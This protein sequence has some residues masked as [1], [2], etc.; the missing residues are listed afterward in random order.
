MFQLLKTRKDD[1]QKLDAFLCNTQVEKANVENLIGTYIFE[2][3]VH[4]WSDMHL[5][6]G[7]NNS[8]FDQ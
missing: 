2:V 8:I 3:L 5:M 4:D 1:C 7:K 6:A